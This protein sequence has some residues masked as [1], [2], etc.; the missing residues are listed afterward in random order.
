MPRFALAHFFACAV[1]KRIYTAAKTLREIDGS[2][3]LM[4][5][6]KIRHSLIT[7]TKLYK[8]QDQKKSTQRQLSTFYYQYLV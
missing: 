3:N 7:F 1:L 4:P 8:K 6:F 5:F 2:N